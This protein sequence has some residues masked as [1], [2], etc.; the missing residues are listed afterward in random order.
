MLRKEDSAEKNLRKLTTESY[1]WSKHNVLLDGDSLNLFL[2]IS[3]SMARLWCDHVQ[4]LADCYKL[5]KS[6]FIL[7]PLNKM[8]LFG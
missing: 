6:L 5:I 7:L 4:N 8:R 1:I 2:Y 3:I